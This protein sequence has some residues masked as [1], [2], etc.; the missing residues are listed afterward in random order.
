MSKAYVEDFQIDLDATC[1]TCGKLITRSN[2]DFKTSSSNLHSKL[3]ATA[4]LLLESYEE[5]SRLR[6]VVEKACMHLNVKP[7]DIQVNADYNLIKNDLS[8]LV[9]QVVY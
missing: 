2:D 3:Q 6:I 4:E 9:Q 8:K 5:Q 1:C 7:S